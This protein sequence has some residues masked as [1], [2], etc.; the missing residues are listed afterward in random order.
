MC[1]SLTRADLSPAGARRVLRCPDCRTRR[2]SFTLLLQHQKAACHQVCKCGGYHYP[3]RPG[4]HCCDANIDAPLH[5][6]MRENLTDEELWDIQLDLVLLTPGKPM[7]K[8][9]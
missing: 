5:R 2:V 7:T 9:E 3:H 6:A 8:W 1:T 4:S